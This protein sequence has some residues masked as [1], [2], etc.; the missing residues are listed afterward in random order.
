M[1]LIAF[2]SLHNQN[3][4]KLHFRTIL[5][6]LINALTSCIM[7]MIIFDADHDT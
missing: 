7:Y 1:R 6:A 3:A 2:N 5:H 4:Y